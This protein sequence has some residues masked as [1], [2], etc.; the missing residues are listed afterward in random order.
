MSLSFEEYEACI[1]QN[2]WLRFPP[3]L[4]QDKKYKTT[5]VAETGEN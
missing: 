4:L 3:S 5:E 2:E 1:D